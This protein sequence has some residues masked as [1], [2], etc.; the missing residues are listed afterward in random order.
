MKVLMCGFLLYVV[1]PSNVAKT[2]IEALQSIR[3]L[4]T[5]DCY[6]LLPF[7]CVRSI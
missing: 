7:G 2:A 3:V 6:K 1:Q 4:N 5:K